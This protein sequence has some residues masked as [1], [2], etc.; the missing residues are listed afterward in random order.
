MGQD[1]NEASNEK[2]ENNRSQHYRIVV[3]ER[4]ANRYFSDLEGIL[5]YLSKHTD[6]RTLGPSGV[7]ITWDIDVIYHSDD[8]NPCLLYLGLG[9]A[10][11][12]LTT[13]GFQSTG[14]MW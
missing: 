11:I 5:T 10:D 8:M 14:V 9:D 4:N 3:Y 13:H 2:K 12:F 6:A 7:D 1:E